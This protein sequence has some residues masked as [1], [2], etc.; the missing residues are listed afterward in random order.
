MNIVSLSKNLFPPLSTGFTQLDKKTSQNGRK[1]VDWDVQ[2]HQKQTN[3]KQ[4]N[5]CLK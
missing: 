2:H 4:Y 1:N 3:I 5:S